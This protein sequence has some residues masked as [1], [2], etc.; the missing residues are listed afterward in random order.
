MIRL[1]AWWV[2]DQT[3]EMAAQAL[4]EHALKLKTNDNVTALVVLVA[5][6]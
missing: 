2:A 3:A 1:C 5:W 6:D 4:V